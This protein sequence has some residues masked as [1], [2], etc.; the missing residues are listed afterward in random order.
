MS[1]NSTTL[2]TGHIATRTLYTTRL[3][4]APSLD[5]PKKKREPLVKNTVKQKC[6]T[7]D[8]KK[9]GEN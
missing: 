4:D 8:N 5:G 2:D 1:W 9:I 7:E 6:E 3:H